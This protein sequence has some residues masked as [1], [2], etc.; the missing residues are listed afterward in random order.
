MY[1]IM[2]EKECVS[3]HEMTEEEFENTLDEYYDSLIYLAT[4]QTHIEI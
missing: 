3:L 1:Y 4:T 2:N